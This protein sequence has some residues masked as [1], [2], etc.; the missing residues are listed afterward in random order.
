MEELKKIAKYRNEEV[1]GRLIKSLQNVE[2]NVRV[3][4]GISRNKIKESEE[5]T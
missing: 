4:E 5:M 1:V 3:Y 2:S